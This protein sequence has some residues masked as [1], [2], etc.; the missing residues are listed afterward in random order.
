MID[1]GLLTPQRLTPSRV[2]AKGRRIR[3]LH[4]LLQTYG[5]HPSGW[6]KRSGP[7][8]QHQGRPHEIHWYHHHGIGS[9]EHKLVAKD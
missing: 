8:F 7:I 1:P 5:G 3:D 9:F 4:R 6:T 2:I